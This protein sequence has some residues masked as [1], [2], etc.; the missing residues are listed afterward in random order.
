MN[1]VEQ[2][3]RAI[4]QANSPAH[5]IAEDEFLAIV[6][7][8]GF[9]LCGAQP[10]GWAA[11]T[12]VEA[13]CRGCGVIGIGSTQGEVVYDGETWLNADKPLYCSI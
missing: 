8:H 5:T 9:Q 11:Q 12:N 4:I 3:V 2:L 1:A 7:S 6:R 13:V 10:V